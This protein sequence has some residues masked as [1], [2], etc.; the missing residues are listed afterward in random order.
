LIW[1]EEGHP[2][3]AE[4]ARALTV[5]D[6]WT[7][8]GLPALLRSFVLAADDLSEILRRNG[9]SAVWLRRLVADPAALRP[10]IYLATADGRLL[11]A[12][13]G[14]DVKVTAAALSAALVK[15][16]AIA[17]ELPLASPPE[18]PGPLARELR[19][20]DSFPLDGLAFEFLHRRLEDA[21]AGPPE[22]LAGTFNRDTF[23]ITAEE[24]TSVGASSQTAGA[25]G[26]W[27]PSLTQRIARAV[28]ADAAEGH[29]LAWSASDIQLAEL[30]S[31]RQVVR[32]GLIGALVTG[33][34]IVTHGGR[35]QGED[36]LPF[37]AG[38]WLAE[39]SGARGARGLAL[40][41]GQ[42]ELATGRL[43]SVQMLVLAQHF[44]ESGVREAAVLMR[45]LQI[46]E[47]A[48]RYAPSVREQIAPATSALHRTLYAEQSP[49]LDGS[50]AEV[51]WTGSPWSLD[52][53]G[54]PGARAKAVWN[55]DALYLAAWTGAPE[56]VIELS[57]P[58]GSKK[59][60]L[61][62]REDGS[63]TGAEGARCAVKSHGKDAEQ[64]WVYELLLPWQIVQQA[65]EREDL[66]VVGESWT[67]NWHAGAGTLTTRLVLEPSRA[68]SESFGSD[69][70][71]GVR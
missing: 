28:L 25:L 66:L 18:R 13:D 69:P 20:A 12:C 26:M 8:P 67:C 54:A 10:G 33:K 30:K 70:F 31:A 52:F 5:R 53:S 63:V 11:G 43:R 48:V 38:Q 4:P 46:S 15:W 1:L 50:L 39:E 40:G 24:G 37:G 65:L 41:W 42:I 3:A 44:D 49:D 34:F 64:A 2:F 32:R 23:W 47:D 35:W 6:L 14:L 16:E 22:Y 19:D 55:S 60:Q 27:K 71:G 7:S 21:S 62:L 36:G 29:A 45:D 17:A 57:P 58:G 51:V 59:L 68:Q 56:L 61:V 9:P